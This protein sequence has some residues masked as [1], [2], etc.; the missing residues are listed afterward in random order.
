M[1]QSQSQKIQAWLDAKLADMRQGGR[2]P[3]ERELADL[4]N[5]SK[6]T[7]A[8]V[9]V[10]YEKRGK[11]FRVVGKGTFAGLPGD[12]PELIG[13]KK[14][15]AE[16]VCDYLVDLIASGKVKRGELLPSPKYLYR[17]FQVAPKTVTI[18]FQMLEKMKIARKVGR[19]MMAGF[20]SFVPVDE[21]GRDIYLFAA[22][23]KDFELI[24]GGDYLA[25]AYKKME[26]EL[27]LN[28]AV[29]HFCETEELTEL[30]RQWK[31]TKRYPHG[32]LFSR[33]WQGAGG[34]MPFAIDRVIADKSFPRPRILTDAIWA[35]LKILRRWGESIHRGHIA[36]IL[37]RNCINYLAEKKHNNAFFFF[38]EASSLWDQVSA[39]W[40]IVRLR[41]EIG[42]VKKGLSAK[43][44]VR[45]KNSQT[46]FA[47]FF[48]LGRLKDE[49][50]R[51]LNKHTPIPLAQF[52]KDVMFASG[53][54]KK[55]LA[56][57]NADVWVF[58]RAARAA[59]ALEYARQRGTRVPED[60]AVLSLQDEPKYHR[61]GIS[62]LG[63]DLERIGYLMAHSL[64]GDMPILHS[65]KGFIEAFGILYKRN[66]TR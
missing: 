57:S 37:A 63:P 40:V 12:A 46:T 48:S 30:Y 35:D 65:S 61:L 31:K 55:L 20:E 50:Q 39:S 60:I 32:I 58:S 22:K 47:S 59:E 66:T 64:L 34:V 17:H 42:G 2:L 51:R 27:V 7:I 25:E 43:F 38:E 14:N 4:F 13:G 6:A 18:A 49:M 16:T 23:E 54:N 33:L 11:L 10:D 9:L 1:K 45:P 19:N 3:T 8:R 21:K 56:K 53:D 36:T 62:Y 24:F 44:I 26:R 5:V 28:N 15:S 29:M 41:A 52:K